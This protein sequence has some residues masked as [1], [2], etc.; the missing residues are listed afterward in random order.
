LKTRR[1]VDLAVLHAY[2]GRG[3]SGCLSFRREKYVPRGGP[4]GGDGGRGGSVILVGDRD[5][6][7]LVR[8]DFT[9]GQRAEPGGNGRGQ[10]RH[11]RNGRD[12]ILKVPLGTVV[13]AKADGRLVGDVVEHGQQFVVA[14]G[15]RGGLGNCHWTTPSHQAP[16]E[17]TDGEAGE[18]VV[19]QLELKLCADVG[20]V[21]LPNAGK[22]SLLSRLSDAHP[23]IGAYPFTTRNPI[24][25]TM[26][27]GDYARLRIADIP[28]LIRGAHAG[29]GLGHDFLRHIER[30]SCLVYVIDMAGADVRVPHEDYANLREELKLYRADLLR[31]PALIAANKM[32][33]PAAAEN[34]KRFRQRTR[35]AP[36]PVSALTGE[37]ISELRAAIG[38][39]WRRHA[40]APPG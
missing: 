23:K 39:L 35:R 19:V 15:G 17:H 13:T 32:D 18:E 11:G 20:L 3:G 10:K 14:H 1:F 8:Y 30:T 40:A 21:G 6:D 36:L 22:S 9:P 38:A 28:G 29:A 25:G 31:R 37:G 33:L 27:F 12:A 16:T 7:S 5:T 26:V 4:D 24:I 2:A 34:L